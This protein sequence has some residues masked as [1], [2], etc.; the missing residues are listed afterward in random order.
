[1]KINKPDFNECVLLFEPEQEA[2][3]LFFEKYKE[4]MNRHSLEKDLPPDIIFSYLFGVV[5]DWREYDS[6]IIKYFSEYIPEKKCQCGRD[7]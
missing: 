6:D 1:M 2:L 4:E 3:D 7:G 5:V